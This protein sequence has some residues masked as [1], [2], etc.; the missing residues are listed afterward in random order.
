MTILIE[1]E[2]SLL[3]EI[4]FQMLFEKVV[5]AA[6]DYVKCPYELSVNVLLTDDKGIH[7]INKQTRNI[8]KATDV[9]SFPMLEY[10]APG[11]FDFINEDDITLFDFESGELLIGDIVISLETAKRQSEEYNHSVIREIAFLLTHSMLHLFGYDHMND[12]ERKTMEALQNKI[13]EGINITR[14]YE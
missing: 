8:D 10:D 3:S 13:L 5:N 9:L 2:S 4:E 1:K 7:E 11:N 6:A 12:D 14:D